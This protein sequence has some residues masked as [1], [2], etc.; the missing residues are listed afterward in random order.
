MAADVSAGRRM[1]PNAHDNDRVD[2]GD[3]RVHYSR[4]VSA[5]LSRRSAVF[6]RAAGTQ[7][8]LPDRRDTAPDHDRSASSFAAGGPHHGGQLPTAPSCDA[9]SPWR[10]S[11]VTAWRRP[12]P[13]QRSCS[14][15]AASGDFSK[16]ASLN[17]P[18]PTWFPGPAF[19]WQITTCSHLP[20]RSERSTH[21]NRRLAPHLAVPA[22][23]RPMPGVPPAG[24]EPNAMSRPVM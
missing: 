24:A 16:A 20:C 18:L 14:S 3:L 23:D 4:G 9:V 19:C 13:L 11:T 2:P 7:P 12:P 22:D 5:R 15:A 17:S 10:S 1:P 21:H 6:A 8:P